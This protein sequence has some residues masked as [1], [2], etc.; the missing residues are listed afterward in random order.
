MRLF[1]LLTFFGVTQ[2]VPPRPRALAQA[3]LA[4]IQGVV[5][6]QEDGKPLPSVTVVVS[7][8]T[9]PDFQSEVTDAAGRYVITQLPPGDDYEVS[10]YFGTADTPHVRRPGIRLS[11]GK[12]VTVSTSLRRRSAQREVKVIQ[13]SAPNIDV[14]GTST[15]VDLNQE[16]LR[17]TP[18]R[19]RTFESALALAPG[20]ADVA[21]RLFGNPAFASPGGEVG[22]SISGATGNE[23]SAIIDG[24]NTTDPG[25]GLLGTELSQYF[26]KEI[27]V[28]TGGYQ[29]EF[30]RATGGVVII[31][32]KSGG[33]E[34]HGSLFGSI[35]P[36]QLDALPVARLG[37]AVSLRTKTLS[38]FD[39]GFDLGGY[40]WKDRIWFYVGFAPTFSSV[41]TERRIR[42]QRFDDSTG[43]AQRDGNFLCPSYLAS[44]LYCLGAQRAAV[45]T[46][47]IEG[48]GQDLM[49]D[50]RLYNWIAK[51]QFNINPDHNITLG[52]IA[53]PVT[54]SD[55]RTIAGAIV[56]PEP[57]RYSRVDQVHDVSVRYTGKLLSR[58][59]QL[60]VLYGF[61]YQS[62]GEQPEQPNV[63]I[64]YYYADPQNPYSLADFENIPGCQRRTVMVG[65]QLTTINPCPLSQYQSGFGPTRENYIG[66]RHMLL[67][68]ATAYL[69]ATH[70]WNPLR[71]IHAIKVGFD[72][73]NV[74]ADNTRRLSGTDLDSNDTSRGH[75]SYSTSGDGT[76]ART[77]ESAQRNIANC[78][79]PHASDP[80]ICLRNGFRGLTQARNYTV[81]LRDS[82][83]VGW[84][85]GL[86]LNAG[87]RWEAQ[88]MYGMAPESD[89]ANPQLGEKHIGIYDNWA[90]R[91]GLAYDFT[92]QTSRPGR[93]KIYFNYGR[94]YQSV[95]MDLSDRVFT[96]EGGYGSSFSATCPNKGAQGR[97]LLDLTS[98]ACNYPLGN[99]FG[100]TYGQVAPG[101]KG[102]YLNE[103]VAG[104]SY[105][106]G[107]DFV[108]GLSYVHR[109][110]GNIIED[111]STD[112]AAHYFIANPGQPTDPD[113]AAL[114]ASAVR[115]EAGA[116]DSRAASEICASLGQ[117][118]PEKL[119]NACSRYQ[120]Y[121]AVGRSFAK[122]RRDYDALVFT[123]SKRLSNRFSLIGSYSYSRTIGNYPGTYSS[124]NGQLNPNNSS[125]FDLTDL[126]A[127]RTGPL[128]TD[129]PHNFKATGFYVQPLGDRSKLTFGLTFTAVSGRPIEVLGTH[130]Y[131]GPY[132]VF[133]LP[134][135]SG[136]RTP[137]ITQF[138]LHIGY[139]HKLS[140]RVNLSLYADLVNLFNQ[141]A[142]TNVED[143]YTVDPVSSIINGKPEDL[144]HL[145]TAFGT[146]PSYNSN[147]GQPTAFQEPL[148]FRFGGRLS[149]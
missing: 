125:Q 8:P 15:G 38:I 120:F 104:L 133:I 45:A 39:V 93:S 54:Y 71:G 47:D 113:Q 134:R 127:N 111:V 115:Q 86:S 137:T 126:L 128:A 67:S 75:R 64:K 91:V 74:T 23:N 34:F 53:A 116:S 80:T 139:D 3:Q 95:P 121:Q 135:G 79:T 65:G 59:L 33:N 142:V 140:S 69:H 13:E 102:Q 105:D 32:T 90:P 77:G 118:A 41:R 25:L 48:I 1:L 62:F 11:L 43:M 16:L 94:Y 46:Q 6:S 50:K 88:E 35:Q 21:P 103:I 146:L 20:A 73:E 68:S 124:A 99:T 30:G 100:G 27:S 61:H 132:E 92:S 108:L 5:I 122:P 40:L 70:R 129:R 10:F 85:P 87:L 144:R 101:L 22:A 49:R 89:F 2:L 12:T 84:A 17:N 28:L 97:P 37:E 123:L 130:L 141:R 19:G 78:P 4:A 57:S 58:R 56:D 42:Q 72:F 44:S 81:Y 29:A 83:Q 106:I 66:Q 149:F 60:D 18:V 24:V 136:G 131:Y 148:Y 145:R 110:L 119:G 52:Y 36:Y 14:A 82:W 63:P 51:L 143:L 55:Y 138:D 26:I 114:L 96:A 76:A 9:L 7:G 109:D 31:A 117:S 147:Y 112:G 107:L 98:S